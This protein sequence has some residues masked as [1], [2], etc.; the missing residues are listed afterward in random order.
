MDSK[1]LKGLYRKLY[2]AAGLLVL[3]TALAVHFGLKAA[4]IQHKLE[5]KSQCILH[6]EKGSYDF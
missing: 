3:S 5:I 6:R 2:F 1:Q 4:N